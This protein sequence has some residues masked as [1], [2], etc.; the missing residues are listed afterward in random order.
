MKKHLFI[1]LTYL[2]SSFTYGQT[3]LQGRINNLL[4]GELHLYNTT[5]HQTDTLEIKNHLFVYKAKLTEPTLFY[6]MVSGYNDFEYPMRLVLS[7][8]ATTFAIQELKAVKKN[9]IWKNLYP[10]RPVFSKD[11]NSN[12]QLFDFES[13]WLIFADSIQRLSS[14]SNQEALLLSKRKQLYEKFIES[15]YRV[16]NDKP[17]KVMTGVILYEYIIRNE[18][19][20]A[21]EASTLFLQLR[22][23]VKY[24]S[25]G[26][27]ISTYLDKEFSVKVGEPAPYFEFKDIHGKEYNL[28]QFKNKTLLLHFWSSTCGPC[29]VQNRE[30]SK[31]KQKYIIMVN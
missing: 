6:M 24:S 13:A 16:V 7:N 22:D 5:T 20:E 19:V 9:T 23:N 15:L 31:S 8:E 29:R 18:L 28:N 4:S 17:S 2:I 25:M 12:N 27:A 30:F 10:N 1:V 3:I 26:V 14:G 11:P 21:N